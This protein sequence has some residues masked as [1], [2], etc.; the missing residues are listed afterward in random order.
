MQN[1]NCDK[2]NHSSRY[3]PSIIYDLTVD[4]SDDDGLEVVVWRTNFEEWWRAKTVYKYSWTTNLDEWRKAATDCKY[5]FQGVRQV[6]LFYFVC[7]VDLSTSTSIATIS[8]I[9]WNIMLFIGVLNKVSH[10]VVMSKFLI[11]AHCSVFIN[12]GLCW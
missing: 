5:F 9:V 10:T 12:P 7:F 1:G 8:F 4:D 6:S 2:F 11:K 3:T